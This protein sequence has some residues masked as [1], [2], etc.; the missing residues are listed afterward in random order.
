M[1]FIEV[2]RI[3]IDLILCRLEVRPTFSA[4]GG[5]FPENPGV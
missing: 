4:G 3:S 1:I 5:A 2:G